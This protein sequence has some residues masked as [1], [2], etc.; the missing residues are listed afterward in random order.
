MEWD[1]LMDCQ[2][3]QEE[4][5]GRQGGLGNFKTAR[6]GPPYLFRL[7]LVLLAFLLALPEFPGNPSSYPNTSSYP[8]VEAC[9]DGP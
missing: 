4:P 3:A 6:G 1:S 5:E 2:G 8:Y 9:H 7:S